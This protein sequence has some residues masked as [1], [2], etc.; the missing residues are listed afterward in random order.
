[1]TDDN[2]Y[3]RPYIIMQLSKFYSA[4]YMK[5]NFHHIQSNLRPTDTIILGD[6]MDS[7]RDWDDNK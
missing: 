3:N 7:G 4:L 5:R 1:M 2:S 6:L